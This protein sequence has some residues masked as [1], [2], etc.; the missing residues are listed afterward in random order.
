MLCRSEISRFFPPRVLKIL[1]NFVFRID[2]FL[3]WPSFSCRWFPKDLSNSIKPFKK[4]FRRFTTL[5]QTNSPSEST[6]RLGLIP[7]ENER[8]THCPEI[9]NTQ[10]F[11]KKEIDCT[12]RHACGI[13]YLITPFRG[14]NFHCSFRMIVD[15]FTFTQL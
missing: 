2:F 15:L 5:T 11:V 12:F 14:G 1:Q 3:Y 6:R 7:T 10:L 8:G 4:E 13:K 9:F